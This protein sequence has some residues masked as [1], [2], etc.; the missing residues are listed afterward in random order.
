M[1]CGSTK[2]A[3]CPIH[4]PACQL[5]QGKCPSCYAKSKK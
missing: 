5:K 2:C 3:T 4:L 1:A